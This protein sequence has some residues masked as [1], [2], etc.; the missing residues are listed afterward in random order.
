MR[1]RLLTAADLPFA[2]GLCAQNHWNQL[3]GDWQRQLDLEPAGCF[4]AEADGQNAGT[5]CYC[6]F[7]DVAWISLVLVDRTKRNQ[8]IG[9]ALLRHVVQALDERG[10]ASILLDATPL[11]QPVYAR[12]GFT[13]EFT[14]AR[15]TGVL[16]ASGQHAEGVEPLGV[17][18]LPDV[19]RLDEAVT[20]TR[21][22]KLLR[23]LYESDPA[24]M[25]KFAP[26]GGLEGFCLARPGANAWQ[27]GPVQGS[28]LAAQRLLLDAAHRFAGQRVYLDVPIDN[29]D[30]VAK[31]QSLGLTEERRFLRMGRG[32][33]V[34]EKLELYWAAFG[35]EKG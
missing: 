19:F 20:G 15:F 6:A 7:G 13:G 23:H 33:R 25:R 31:A 1:I 12:L 24:R 8:G 22:E 3:A 21:R 9:T 35:P 4:V 34:P 16:S 27:M 10:V 28:S 5:A 14:L 32:P 2:L 17:A 29:A 30:A 11:G 26:A 18:D